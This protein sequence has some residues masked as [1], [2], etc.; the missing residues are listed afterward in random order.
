[1]DSRKIII[2]SLCAITGLTAIAVLA[3]ALNLGGIE[4]HDDFVPWGLSVVLAE[5]VGATIFVLK[6][7]WS[8]R[9][10]VN[11][12]NSAEDMFDVDFTSNGCQF[13]VMDVTGK[14]IKTGNAH[15]ICGHGGWS[16]RIP[17]NVAPDHSLSLTLETEAGEKWKVQPFRPLVQTQNVVK[18]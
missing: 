9:I 12:A 7:E 18:V 3:A 8:S 10:D 16:V 1:M 11:L 2:I 14:H 5:I 17:V 15:P 4:A 13:V 6:A